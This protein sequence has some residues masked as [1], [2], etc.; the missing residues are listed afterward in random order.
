M[1]KLKK[2]GT[3]GLRN[4][5]VISIIIASILLICSSGL[6]YAQ[7]EQFVL[8]IPLIECK[9]TTESSPDEIFMVVTW[10]T[11]YGST[12]SVTIPQSRVDMNDGD[13]SNSVINLGDIYGFRL[14]PGESI[15]FV[16]SILEEDRGTPAQYIALGQAI[17]NHLPENNTVVAVAQ[18]IISVAE[19]ISRFFDNIDTD[20]WIG[21]MYFRVTNNARTFSVASEGIYNGNSNH[22]GINAINRRTGNESLFH[23]A[24]DGSFYKVT[25]QVSPK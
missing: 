23:F 5:Q 15:D 10:K 20:D 7:R 18:A 4:P 3:V 19:V 17:L 6:V 2:A 21:S 12:G 8:R 1:Q 13:R 24:G 25:A 11:T 14:A 22:N 9:S 16:V